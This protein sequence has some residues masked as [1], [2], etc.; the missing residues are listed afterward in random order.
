[1][2]G[3]IDVTFYFDPVC[4]FSYRTS[5]WIREVRRLRPIDV[6][7]RFLSLKAINESLGNIRE[8]HSRS[9]ASFQLMA[10]A[11][12]EVGNDA[13]DKLYSVIGRLHN[14]DRKDISDR[15][16]L[17]DAAAEAGID[18]A[19]VAQSLSDDSMVQL[20]QEDHE[21]GVAKGAF[22]VASIEIGGDG[23]AFFGP[24]LR[25]VVTGERAGEMWDHFSWMVAQPEFLEVKRERK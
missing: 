13:V 2:S 21:S 18:T 16:V 15:G 14:V 25:D 20:V 17:V 3:R 11:R 1:V 23:R 24:V 19:L 9:L 8:T 22:G 5:L 4:P 7:W 10:K 12:L 6:T